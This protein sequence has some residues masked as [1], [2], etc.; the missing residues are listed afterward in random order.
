MTQNLVPG[1]T[2]LGQTCD[3]HA[4]HLNKPGEYFLHAMQIPPI[5]MSFP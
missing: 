2:Q 4:A 3:A 5:A 1:I